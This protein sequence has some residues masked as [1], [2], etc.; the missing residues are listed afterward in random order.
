VQVDGRTVGE[1]GDGVLV[2]LGVFREDGPEDAEKLAAKV[3][4][5]RF[6]SDQEGRMARSLVDVGGAAL[7]VSQVTLVA[8]GRKGRRPSLD[9]AASPETA[10]AL[11]RHFRARLEA[12]GVPTESGVF[13]AMMEVELVNRG[14]VTFVLDE[15]S[16]G[17]G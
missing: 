14:P 13:G 17:R 10:D 11:Y 2:L 16:A 3:A 5:F 6:F 4:G 9:R 12:A 7:V 8:D 1:I 15:P